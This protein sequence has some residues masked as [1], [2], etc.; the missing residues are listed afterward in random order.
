MSR[1]ALPVGS[2][3]WSLSSGSGAMRFDPI[4][5][6][7]FLLLPL[8]AASA[9]LRKSSRQ[10][11]PPIPGYVPVYIQ[12]GDIPPD[13]SSLV[14]QA[15]ASARDDTAS[16]AAAAADDADAPLKES[17]HEIVQQLTQ[18]PVARLFLNSV[19]PPSHNTN[20]H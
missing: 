19:H 4:T 13:V 10:Y 20:K 14:R 9:A 18:G 6:L 5:V 3:L 16:D 1:P 2:S 15:A 17:G 11:L 8:L 7:C 12:D